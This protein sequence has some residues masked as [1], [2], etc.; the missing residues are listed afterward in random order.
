MELRNLLELQLVVDLTSE[1]HLNGIFS[2]FHLCPLPCLEKLFIQFPSNL[3]QQYD[4][5]HL[6]PLD[7][8]FQNLKWIKITNYD[9]SP[10]ELTLVKYLLEDPSSAAPPAFHHASPSATGGESHD[11]LL[12][13]LHNFGPAK[14]VLSVAD[15][16]VP[17]LWP[18]SDQA[19]EPNSVES[20]QSVLQVPKKHNV[21]L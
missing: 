15:G 14:S 18:Q 5:S 2:F 12:R 10:H 13:D 6:E 21:D 8:V 3:D 19:R 17:Q 7:V 4:I 9:G 16:A 1:E 11:V 20:K